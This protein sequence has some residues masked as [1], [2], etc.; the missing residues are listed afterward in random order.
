M[1]RLELVGVSTVCIVI[2]AMILEVK[3]L[4]GGDINMMPLHV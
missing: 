1:R 3:V 4:P 2:Y